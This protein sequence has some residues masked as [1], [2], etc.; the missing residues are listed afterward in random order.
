MAGILRG[1]WGTGWPHDPFGAG[2]RRRHGHSVRTAGGSNATRRCAI[3]GY[4]ARVGGDEV[5][6]A[7][8]PFAASCSRFLPRNNFLI[9]WGM[10]FGLISSIILFP[11]PPFGVAPRLFPCFPS[12]LAREFFFVRATPPLFYQRDH[13][14]PFFHPFTQVSSLPR[15]PSAPAFRSRTHERPRIIHDPHDPTD[16]RRTRPTDL[17]T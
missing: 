12:L 2:A 17:I 15:P 5:T 10:S 7:F 1:D 13:H 11:P 16:N 14:L 4:I 6:A 9:W 8:Y 3:S